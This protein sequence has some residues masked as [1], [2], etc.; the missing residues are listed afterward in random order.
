MLDHLVAHLASAACETDSAA[1]TRALDELRRAHVT[2]MAL[3]SDYIPE[4]A[5]RLGEGWQNDTLSFLDVTL[6]TSRLSELLHEVGGDW[7]GDDA[8]GAGRPTVLLVVP[9]GEQHTLGAAVLACRM[10]Q[11]GVSVCLRI[12]PGLTELAAL[13]ATRGFD[14]AMVTLA[15]VEKVESCAV[16]VRALRTLGKGGLPVVVGGAALQAEPGLQGLT[17]ADL[18][19]NSLEAALAL[20]GVDATQKT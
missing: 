8:G 5:R 1:L 6:G 12:A 14:G 3:V 2:D 9:P 17:G 20:F 11:Q 18:A 4:A 15:N 7:K 16:L 19:T 13:I 10:R